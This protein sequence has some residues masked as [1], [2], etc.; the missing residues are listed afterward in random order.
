MS[1]MVRAIV[2]SVTSVLSFSCSE[3]L[4]LEG[5]ASLTPPSTPCSAFSCSRRGLLGRSCAALTSAPSV[6]AVADAGGDEWQR[7]AEVYDEAA[8]DYDQQ[9]SQSV[10]SKILDFLRNI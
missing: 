3:S 10:V 5:G 7:V 1:F 8:A 9:Y 6:V 4:T 2:M